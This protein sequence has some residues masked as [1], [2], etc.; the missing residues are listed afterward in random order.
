MTLIDRDALAS[1]LSALECYLAEIESFLKYDRAEFV[2]TPAIHHLAERYLHL[3]C[4]C[5]LDI[6][7]HVIAESGYRQPESYRDAIEVLRE[8]GLLDSSLAERLKMWVGFRNVLVHF[9]LRLDHARVY[10]AIRNDLSDL[11]AFARAMA[12]LLEET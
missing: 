8:R 2:A 10:D 11:Y 7:H 9:Y 3:A 12:K 5:V 4:E 1:R 6:A